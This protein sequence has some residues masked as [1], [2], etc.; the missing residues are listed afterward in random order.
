MYIILWI[1][2][3]AFAAISVPMFMGKQSFFGKSQKSGYNIKKASLAS[4][5][6]CI[7]V[8]VLTGVAAFFDNAT[9][10]RYIM[11]A[12]CILIIVLIVYG[13]KKCKK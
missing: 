6:F 8:S 11:I 12:L 9:I 3:A 2:C 1:V 7:C 13:E 10:T 4:G 5:V